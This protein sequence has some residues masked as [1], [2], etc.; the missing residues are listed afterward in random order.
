MG[1]MDGNYPPKMPRT[2]WSLGYATPTHYT[3]TLEKVKKEGLSPFPLSKVEKEFF[4]H[5]SF[6]SQELNSRCVFFIPKGSTEYME[7]PEGI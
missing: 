2:W 3:L 1:V 5:K 6:T 4:D 7:P